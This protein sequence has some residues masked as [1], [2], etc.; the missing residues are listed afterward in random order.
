MVTGD[1]AQCAHYIGRACG[2]I[3]EAA[4]VLLADV[5]SAG[6][7]AWTFV[8]N[9][10]QDDKLRPTFTTAQARLLLAEHRQAGC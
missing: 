7:V 2:M 6:E 3:E 9:G 1:S 5:D 10:A 4:D 8:G